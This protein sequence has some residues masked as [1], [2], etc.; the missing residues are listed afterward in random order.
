MKAR[1]A[2]L[3]LVF[4]TALCFAQSSPNCQFE[5]VQAGPGKIGQWIDKGNWLDVENQR[6]SL[7]AGKVFMPALRMPVA[8]GARALPAAARQVDIGKITA[9]DPFDGRRQNLAFLLDSRLSADGLLVLS[10]GKIVAERYRNG[11]QQEQPRLLRQGS[12]P[13]LNLLGAISMAQGKLS[14]NKSVPRY[15]QALG[16]QTGLRKLSVRRL[17]KNEEHYRWLDDD[18]TNWRNAAGWNTGAADG[19]VRNWMAQAERWD[20]PLVERDLLANAPSPDDDLLAWLLSE[21]HGAPLSRLFCEQLFARNPPENEVIWLTDQAGVELADG[22]S[23]SLRDF[24]RLGQALLGARTNRSSSKLPGWFI[25]TLLASSGPR[26]VGING[27]PAG[28][29]QRY[30]FIHVGGA[31]NRIA[32]IGHRGASLFIDF[33]R[34]LIVALYATFPGDNS[35]LLLATLESLWQSVAQAIGDNTR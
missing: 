11:L 16:N 5:K 19:G 31:P 29:E 17:L 24:S 4:A 6:V 32:L 28:S 1:L 30:G 34:R 15:I 23:L 9:I 27:L 26:A 14:A 25:E 7:Q 20:Q 12:R 21:S 2:A 10:N 8:A 22:L 35:A 13:F 33:D 18:L 3:P